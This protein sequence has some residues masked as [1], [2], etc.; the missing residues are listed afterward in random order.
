MT[1]PDEPKPIEAWLPFLQML[2]GKSV[3]SA[4]EAA[5][6]AGACVSCAKGCGAC[7]RQLVA[8]SLVEARALAQLVAETPQPGQSEIRRRFADALRRITDKR[9]A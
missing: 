4:D 9:R 6:G 1:V 7:C 8:I 5:E 2:A 3:Q